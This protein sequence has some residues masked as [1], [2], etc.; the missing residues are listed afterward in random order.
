M[1]ASAKLWV[2]II[3]TIISL[4]GFYLLVGAYVEGGSIMQGFLFMALAFAF[5]VIPIAFD[6]CMVLPEDRDSE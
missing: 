3:C 1:H 6:A 4:Y 5:I 2:N